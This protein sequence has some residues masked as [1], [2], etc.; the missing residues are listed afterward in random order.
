MRFLMPVLLT[1]ILLFSNSAFS[2]PVACSDVFE[3]SAKTQKEGD[4]L[5]IW[6][7]ENDQKPWFDEVG[8]FYSLLA[9]HESLSDEQQLTN[10][11][12]LRFVREELTI[13]LT[14]AEKDLDAWKALKNQLAQ[15]DPVLAEKLERTLIENLGRYI[16]FTQKAILS[17][18]LRYFEFVSIGRYT[19]RMSEANQRLLASDN[20]D[21]LSSLLKRNWKFKNERV[22]NIV[23]LTAPPNSPLYPVRSSKP[24]IFSYP[25]PGKLDQHKF[26]FIPTSRALSREDMNALSD[27]SIAVLGITFEPLHVDGVT[28]SP[29]EFF[30]H[31]IRHALFQSSAGESNGPLIE[32]FFRNAPKSELSLRNFIWF[33]YWHESISTFDEVAKSLR[34]VSGDVKNHSQLVTGLER[35]DDDN[36]IREFNSPKGRRILDKMISEY[37][38]TKFKPPKPILW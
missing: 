20:P 36:L 10:V 34:R 12:Q 33:H 31:D 9:Q 1:I 25:S 22:E 27:R 32:A 2:H 3:S 19:A 29:E 11:G 13:W 15:Q 30:E 18:D 38:Q 26:V 7:L 37:E 6:K 21:L 5:A 17:G 8:E 23:S 14:N 4:R 16:R 35:G 24:F 28:L